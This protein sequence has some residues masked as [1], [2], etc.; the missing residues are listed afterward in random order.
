M[1]K[2]SIVS[3]NND[4]EYAKIYNTTHDEWTYSQDFQFLANFRHIEH[5][6]ADIANTQIYIIATK[7]T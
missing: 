1:I 7:N 2:T 3:Y 5:I 4:N 6:A